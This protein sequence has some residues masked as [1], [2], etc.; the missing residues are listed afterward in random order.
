VLDVYGFSFR[1]I[2]L[3]SN[4]AINP[5]NNSKEEMLG[6]D[7]PK[8]KITTRCIVWKCNFESPE[9]DIFT[10]NWIF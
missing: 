2:Y 3:D 4:V 10:F 5:K 6:I 8:W 9:N 1:I 7:A